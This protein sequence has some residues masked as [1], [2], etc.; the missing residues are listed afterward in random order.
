MSSF[1]QTK[2]TFMQP[3]TKQENKDTGKR[4]ASL[5]PA[6]RFQTPLPSLY[7]R[8]PLPYPKLTPP[9]YRATTNIQPLGILTKLDWTSPLRKYEMG[10]SL[11]ELENGDDA[12]EYS[13]YA[14]RT[15]TESARSSPEREYG[16]TL[17]R[18]SRKTRPRR[19][20]RTV[21]RPM[22]R[23]TPKAV[24]NVKYYPYLDTESV[25]SDDIGTVNGEY[26]DDDYQSTCYS[27]AGDGGEY[28]Y[29][30]RERSP[31]PIEYVPF[32]PRH[33]INL[34]D[35]EYKCQVPSV[36]EMA[37]S[38]FVPPRNDD[39]L[40]HDKSRIKSD[41][42][43]HD[44]VSQT[45]SKARDALKNVNLD[46]YDSASLVISVEGEYKDPVRGE[47]MGFQYIARPLALKGPMLAGPAVYAS[48][49]SDSA[50]NRYMDDMRSFRAQIRNRLESGYKT[51]SSVSSKVKDYSYPILASSHRSYSRAALSPP[52]SSSA[53]RSVSPV[54]VPQTSY[55][56]Q[57]LPVS[58]LRKR[59]EE[60][61]SRYKTMGYG[62]RLDDIPDRLVVYPISEKSSIKPMTA[63]ENLPGHTKTLDLFEG[64]AK[65][66]EL[67]TLEKINIKVTG[68]TEPVPCLSLYI[69]CF[70][71]NRYKRTIVYSGLN[72]LFLSHRARFTSYEIPDSL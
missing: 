55:S 45:A 47:N 31:S 15:E 39:D 18:Y 59:L 13:T 2:I 37:V 69:C 57:S 8:N 19:R 65:G 16:D 50:F 49:A 22:P 66:N 30:D 28:Y 62:K 5:I 72:V 4:T 27:E 36:A 20:I 52:R 9:M 38:H 17:T 26:I 32:A 68:M 42:L 14:T 23:R 29:V 10:A 53:R 58:N 6:R 60:I 54:R 51:L 11:P 40:D 70:S 33:K 61:E 1:C 7:P 43:F 35:D 25:G 63:T 56:V 64:S 46:E 3:S 24:K 41:I 48:T 21:Y 67:S 44:V 12:S 34:D 71:R